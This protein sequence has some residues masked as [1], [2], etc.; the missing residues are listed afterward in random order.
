MDILNQRFT[1]AELQ[2]MI[3]NA[4]DDARRAAIVRRDMLSV[5]Q[6]SRFEPALADRRR[7]LGLA[8]AYH[9]VAFHNHAMRDAMLP[10]WS[11]IV[12]EANGIIATHVR[13]SAGV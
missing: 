7:P 6:P 8:L 9:I 4:D 2:T 10:E 5:G 1:D 13:N 3:D 12:A 11:V